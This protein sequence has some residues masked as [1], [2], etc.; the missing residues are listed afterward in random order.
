M[1]QT[2][3]DSLPKNA[4][5]SEM[6][7]LNIIKI[8]LALFLIAL[9]I[10]GK[11][12]TT[13]PL[14]T[15][16]LYSTY[17]ESFQFPSQTA[18]TVELRAFLSSGEVLTVRPETLI[19]QTRENLSK[20]ILNNVISQSN[21]EVGNSTQSYILSIFQEKIGG[22]VEIEFVEV[23]EIS[24]EVYPLKIPPLERDAPSKMIYL[25]SFSVKKD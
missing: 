25:G 16:T 12:K 2:K 4:T 19:T 13:W 18:S 6:L 20:R 10:V 15:W 9:C 22:D 5:Q 24:Y 1:Q 14:I 21:S 17:G 8:S 3:G 23:W 7:S 11:R